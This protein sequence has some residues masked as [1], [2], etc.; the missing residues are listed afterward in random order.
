MTIDELITE[1]FRMRRTHGNLNVRFWDGDNA[2]YADVDSLKYHP[3]QTERH[4][5]STSFVSVED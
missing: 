4:K 3:I 2:Y 5:V 1:L